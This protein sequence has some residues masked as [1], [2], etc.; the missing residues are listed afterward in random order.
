MTEGASP[1]ARRGK[2]PSRD[3]SMQGCIKLAGLQLQM[4]LAGLRALAVGGR[5]VYRWG[6]M[7]PRSVGRTAACPLCAR[8]PV[9][10]QGGAPAHAHGAE[11]QSVAH[12]NA[13]A[14]IDGQRVMIDSP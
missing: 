10:P 11:A 7:G 8:A 6:L 14:S 2:I 5:L 4:L 1:R 13:A 9:W 12:P 3:W